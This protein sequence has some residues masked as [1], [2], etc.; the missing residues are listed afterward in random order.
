MSG[1]H[2]GRGEAL[3][4]PFRGRPGGEHDEPLL[5][6]IISARALPLDAPAEMHDLARILAD[7][8][9][10][11]EPGDLAGEAAV[12]AAFSR[13]APRAGVSAAARPG[14]DRRSRRPARSR[15]RLATVMVAAVTGSGAVLA[16]YADLMPAPAQQLAHVVVAAPAPRQGPNPS[17]V[18]LGTGM[19]VPHHGSHPSPTHPPG[20]R[21]GLSPLRPFPSAV[22]T[23]ADTGGTPG[24]AASSHRCNEVAPFP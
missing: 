3:G 15:V 12:R 4:L 10:P 9:G 19:P 14:R 18:N 8:T 21:T 11:A 24:S 7:L 23:N 5:D 20:R 6:M 2:A 17:P 16:A 13:A 22:F 1:P